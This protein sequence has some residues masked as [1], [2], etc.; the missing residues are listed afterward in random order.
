MSAEAYRVAFDAALWA[1]DGGW[2]RAA[3]LAGRATACVRAFMGHDDGADLPEAWLPTA[4]R[5]AGARVPDVAALRSGLILLS[6][7]ARAALEA[8]D[9]GRHR[10]WTVAVEDAAGRT[11]RRHG[12]IVGA[13]GDAILE[14]DSPVRVEP[15]QPA[16]GLPRRA[17]LAEGRAPRID[18]ARRPEAALWWDHG[19]SVPYL[20]CDGALAAD[21][22]GLDVPPLPRCGT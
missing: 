11:R 2:A 6:D 15:P 14:R 7:P 3:M 1:D 22:A 13:R 12:L 19:L 20:L 17:T 21:W 8:R 4:L 16:L 10:L 9:P 5:A 18:P